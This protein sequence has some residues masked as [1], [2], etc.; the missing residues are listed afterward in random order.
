MLAWLSDVRRLGETNSS[1]LSHVL[2][3]SIPFSS[4]YHA[5]RRFLSR[6]RGSGSLDFESTPI[7]NVLHLQVLS[8]KDFQV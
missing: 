1:R 7:V 4:I 2:I 6:S 5:K 3:I 8:F